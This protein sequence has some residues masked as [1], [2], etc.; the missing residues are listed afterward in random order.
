M[1]NDGIQRSDSISRGASALS[2]IRSAGY[3][4]DA[5]T[6]RASSAAVTQQLDC[7]YAPLLA[8]AA[9]ICETAEEDSSLKQAVALLKKGAQTQSWYAFA[10]T[11][12]RSVAS[13][14]RAMLK[15]IALASTREAGKLAIKYVV[16][17]AMKAAPLAIED[18][19]K[20][21]D[22]KKPREGERQAGA[23]AAA[24]DNEEE[25]EQG[26]ERVD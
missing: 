6:G 16:A 8:I 1:F 4:F 13:S 9:A 17:D 5:G 20:G 15:D 10:L 7:S 3:L 11:A 25:E 21:E 23:D 2:L 12:H 22:K 19:A 18:E 24:G 14:R 26:P